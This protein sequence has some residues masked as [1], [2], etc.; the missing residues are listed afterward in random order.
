MADTVL[1]TNGMALALQT[2]V[3][4]M[5]GLLINGKYFVPF[6]DDSSSVSDSGSQI[7]QST[8]TMSITNSGSFKVLDAQGA[9]EVRQSN[10][11]PVYYS[12]FPVTVSVSSTIL[13]AVVK[14]DVTR[15]DCSTLPLSN[16]HASGHAA[17]QELNVN[18]CG[19]SYLY[20]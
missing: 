15:M 2:P 5:K 1:V 4:E 14:G 8:I 19:L 12:T 6:L 10:G 11:D 17:I 18:S 7:G 20:I 3:A 13:S 16:L 9:I